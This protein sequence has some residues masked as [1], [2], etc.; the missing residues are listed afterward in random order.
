[1]IEDRYAFPLLVLFGRELKVS[2]HPALVIQAASVGSHSL[3]FQFECLLT[4]DTH[5]PLRSM[6]AGVQAPHAM[7]TRSAS[8]RVSS[9][10]TTPV[11][12]LPDAERIGL[13]KVPELKRCRPLASEE[14]P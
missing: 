3:A 4:L 7:I 14:D 6:S 10:Q 11:H 9:A 1:M 13:E 5:C 2:K 12:V 8:Y